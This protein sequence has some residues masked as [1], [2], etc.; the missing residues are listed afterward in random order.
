MKS[1]LKK[2]IIQFF[3][4]PIGVISMGIF[5]L[6]SGLFLWVIQGDYN[7]TE[8]RFA[9]LLPFFE[10]APWILIF[11][12]SAISMKSFSEEYKTGTIETLLTKPIS[13][14]EVIAA[15][16]LAVW[17]IGI[18]ML[19]PS[20][21]Y[22]WTIAHWTQQGQSIEWG[23][24]FGSYLGLIFLIGVFSAIGIFSSLL[25]TSQVNAFLTALFLMFLLYYGLE[26]IG[27]FNLF[28]SLDYWIQKASLKFHYNNFIKGLIKLS[29]IFYFLSIIVIF[30]S[31]ANYVIHQKQK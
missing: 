27:N 18:I 11:V 3:S 12:M 8:H 16:F 2:E 21:V 1:I 22:V 30:I 20:F 5:Y 10:L 17:I 28:G 25:F 9:D 6:L 31:S 4:S 23:I 13:V 24:I 19:I 15:K 26:G 14:K 29:D 7:I